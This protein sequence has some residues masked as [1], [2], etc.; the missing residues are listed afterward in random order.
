MIG[1]DKE[2]DDKWFDK[3]HSVERAFK[4][5]FGEAIQVFT[6]KVRAGGTSNNVYVPK[7]FVGNPV[8]IIIWPKIE[9]EK[10]VA[11]NTPTEIKKEE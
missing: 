11:E 3:L 7:K 10:P 4:T 2:T 5:I 6:K 9:E 1:S 8:T